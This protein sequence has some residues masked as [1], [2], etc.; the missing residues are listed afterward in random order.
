MNL[1]ESG[2]E[3]P[4]IRGMKTMVYDKWYGSEKG[5]DFGGNEGA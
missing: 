3:P 5:R 4:E 2:G 1:N